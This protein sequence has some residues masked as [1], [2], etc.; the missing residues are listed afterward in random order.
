MDNIFLHYGTS[1]FVPF[2]FRYSLMQNIFFISQ[3][4]LV[5]LWIQYPGL[6]SFPWLDKSVHFLF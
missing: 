4:R 2:Y 1:G 6:Y 3:L 5:F